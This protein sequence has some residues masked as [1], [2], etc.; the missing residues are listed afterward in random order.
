[1]TVRLQPALP[2]RAEEESEGNEFASDAAGKRAKSIF[3]PDKGSDE[4]SFGY[5]RL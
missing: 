1:M 5:L 2:G 3:F 4:K